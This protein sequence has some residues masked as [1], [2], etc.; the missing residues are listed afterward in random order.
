[1]EW[2]TREAIGKAGNEVPDIIYDTGGPGKEPMMRV[3]GTDPADVA[4]KVRRI[5]RELSD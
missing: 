5:V 4:D 3:M 2:G 1:M